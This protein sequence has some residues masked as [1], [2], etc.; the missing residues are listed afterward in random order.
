MLNAALQPVANADERD[1]QR[2]RLMADATGRTGADSPF[3]VTLH[4]VSET[5]LLFETDTPL[6]TGSAFLIG[7]PGQAEVSATIVWSSNAYHGVQFE[8]PIPPSA[9]RACLADSKIVWPWATDQADDRAAPAPVRTAPLRVDGPAQALA[10][11][12]PLSPARRIQILILISAV[13]WYGLARLT[14]ALFG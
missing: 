4:N 1:V 3:A 8:R 7:L 5:G 9:I 14:L 11:D 13:L 6:R 10:G 12:D 2:Y